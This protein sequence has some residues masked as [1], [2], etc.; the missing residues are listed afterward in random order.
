M[1]TSSP[2]L[3]LI[4]K[5]TLTIKGSTI[6]CIISCKNLLSGYDPYVSIRKKLEKLLNCKFEELSLIQ[7]ATF[8][9][10]FVAH[11]LDFKRGDEVINTD[12]EH[13]GGFAAWRQLAKRKG[14]VYKVA[15][16]PVPANDK[17]QLLNQ[18]LIKLLKKQK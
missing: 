12:Q 5:K 17:E 16:M 4:L 8:G 14:V 9:M 13:G 2:L 7:N 1:I 3:K 10:N 11:G 6:N 15:R 18:F